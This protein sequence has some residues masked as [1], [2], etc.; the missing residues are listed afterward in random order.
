MISE[1]RRIRRGRGDYFDFRKHRSVLD[2]RKDFAVGFDLGAVFIGDQVGEHLVDDSMG[3]KGAGATVQNTVG[4]PRV[5]SSPGIGSD[6][7]HFGFGVVKV[8]FADEV[9]NIAVAVDIIAAVTEDDHQGV[10][11]GMAENRITPE[12]IPLAMIH[13]PLWIFE[14]KVHISL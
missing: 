1:E 9:L 10:F 6:Q 11:I 5:L 8:V 4:D 3:V 12:G 7:N 14:V 2:C 13:I